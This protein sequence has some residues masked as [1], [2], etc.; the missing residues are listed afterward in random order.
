MKIFLSLIVMLFLTPD[1]AHSTINLQH[2]KT[3]P[4]RTYSMRKN[5]D[6]QST[7]K[8]KKGFPQ[9][10]A[11]KITALLVAGVCFVCGTTIAIVAWNFKQ[12]E[13]LIDFESINSMGPRAYVS[14]DFFN[15]LYTALSSNSASSHQSKNIKTIEQTA[16]KQVLTS[17]YDAEGIVQRTNII[18]ATLYQVTLTDGTIQ[19]FA[20]D[21]KNNIFLHK[22]DYVFQYSEEI[23]PEY[24]APITIRL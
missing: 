9:K 16:F 3:A 19:S 10:H 17:D 20:I 8:A 4:A 11:H 1:F 22:Q 18:N 21:E 23:N 7:Q 2:A 24:W 14:Q 13:K 6:S 5:I 12:Q 15:E